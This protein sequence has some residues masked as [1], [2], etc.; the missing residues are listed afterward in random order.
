MTARTFLRNYATLFSNGEKGIRLDKAEEML[1]DFALMHV[2]DAL[3]AVTNKAI[4]ECDSIEIANRA[5]IDEESVFNSYPAS[6][7]E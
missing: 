3:I 7:I 5:S 1:K 4:I 6:K 2:Q